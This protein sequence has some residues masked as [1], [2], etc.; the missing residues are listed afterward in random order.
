MPGR[1]PLRPLRAPE[2]P[3]AVKSVPLRVLALSL[4]AFG[5]AIVGAFTSPELLAGYDALSWLLLLVP[6]FLLAYYRG[7]RGAVRVLAGGSLLLLALE[8]AAARL[9]GLT[10]EWILLFLVALSL[11]AIGLGLGVLSELLHRER[12]EALALAYNDP[13]TA[14]PNR[15]LLEFQLDKQFAAALQ[16]QPFSLALFD[17][18]GFQEY[19]QRFGYSAGDE[20]LRRVAAC[21]N[22][23]T[24]QVNMCGRYGGDEFLAILSGEAV[25]GASI[26]AERARAAVASIP[27][28]AGAVTVSVGVASFAEATRNPAQIIGDAA[29]ALERAREA[30]GNRCGVAGTA[31]A[32]RKA[33]PVTT[34]RPA[35]RSALGR[36]ERRRVVHEAE[37]RHRDVFQGAPVGLYRQTLGGQ[38]IEA[39]PALIALL[40][41]PDPQLLLR[42]NAAELYVD[43]ADRKQ[44]EETVRRDGTVRDFETRLRR[45][46]GT[47]IWVRDSAR[48][49]SGGG[50]SVMYYEGALED[51]TERKKAEEALRHANQALR[52]IIQATPL[53]IISLDTMGNVKTWN[54]AAERIFGWAESEVVGRPLPVVPADSDG[55]LRDVFRV[56][57][58]G[59]PLTEVALRLAR[60]DGS[61]LEASVWAEPL[62][63][64]VGVVNGLL[65]VVADVT[66]RR[67]LEVQLR[68]SQ[69]MESIGRLAG[70]VAH[71]FNNLL[72]AILSQCEN[73]QSELRADDPHHRDVREISEVAERAASLTRQ[74]LSFS[75]KEVIEPQRLDLNAI[76]TN[77]ERMIQRLIGEDVQLLTKLLPGPSSIRADPSHIEQLLVNLAVNARDAMPKGGKLTIETNRIDVGGDLE[78]PHVLKPGS[79]VV[80]SVRDTGAGMDEATLARVFEP[81]FT[82]KANGKGT[83]LGLSVV[84]GIVEGCGGH[85]GVDS[86]PGQGTTFTV[87]LP[88]VA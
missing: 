38:F 66:E 31:G 86:A 50:G 25:E 76:I 48:A 34:P 81:F 64:S 22:G 13:L 6:A 80:L 42:A 27:L 72:T 70:G 2:L 15:K 85:I 10:V 44:W 47:T 58:R 77:I 43:P 4:A 79:Y 29:D 49:I 78:R 11:L 60:R 19:N 18:D 69:K 46:D 45:Y 36:A 57:L 33:K 51:I 84:Y 55:M 63:D 16:G 61:T 41:Y 88:Q 8:L 52:A 23:T 67:Q 54:A 12:V 1:L 71:D 5:V 83:G 14:L 40:G 35:A 20:A 9:L 87:F 3:G 68:H 28:P 74:L 59:E 39:N 73:L 7:W 56:V 82:T 26:Y 62:Y 65:A 21:L 30:G 53:A 32:E 24:R 37:V 17:I 75:R